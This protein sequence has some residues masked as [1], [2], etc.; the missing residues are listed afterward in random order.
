M[1]YLPI[2]VPGP[3]IDEVNA[4]FWENC[5]AR[6]LAFQQCGDCSHLIHPPLPVCPRCQSVNRQ[7]KHAPH[8]ATV[9]SFVWVHT[10]AHDSVADC[11]P[12]NVALVEFPDMPGVRL[13]T[14][15]VNAQIGQLAF[16]DRVTIEWEP[17]GDDQMLPRFRKLEKS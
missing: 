2:T 7:W 13:V 15:V 3:K 5:R 1:P 8:E 10:A 11:L 4:P 6:R 9:Y 17:G 12:Y 14:N 16:G